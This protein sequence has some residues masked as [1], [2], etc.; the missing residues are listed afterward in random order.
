MRSEINLLLKGQK[1]KALS[2]R[3]LSESINTQM[4]ILKITWE[5][6]PTFDYIHSSNSGVTFKTLD[7]QRYEPKKS[8]WLA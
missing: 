1:K 4:H 8:L 3:Y 7:C 2:E 6:G 5:T